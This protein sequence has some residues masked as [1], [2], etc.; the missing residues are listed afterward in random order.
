MDKESGEAVKADGKEIT[1]SKTFTPEKA[2]GTVTMVFGFRQAELY[3]KT[4]RRLLK[5]CI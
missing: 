2:N 5:L 3:G 1:A 4:N